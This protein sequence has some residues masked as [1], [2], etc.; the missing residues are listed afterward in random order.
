MTLARPAWLYLAYA[1]TLT[2]GMA[3]SGL[4]FNLLLAARGYGEATLWLPVVG[5]RSL[6]G[7]MNSL[8]VLAAG[9]SSLPLWWL[10]GRLGPRVA[11]LLGALLAAASLLGVALLRTPLPALA[12]AC[13]GGPAAVLFQVS[14]A[15]LMMRLSGPHA[16]DLLFSI[17]AGANIGVG[18]LGSLA[19]GLIAGALADRLGLAPQSEAAYSATFIVAAGIVLLALAP[20]LLLR[21]SDALQ[22]ALP[23][24]GPTTNDQPQAT[25]ASTAWPRA[26]VPADDTALTDSGKPW[27]RLL[28]AL[29]HWSMVLRQT[30][31]YLV[32]PLLISCGAALLIPYLSL[33]FRLRYGAPDAALGLIFALIG[34]STGAA[35]LLAPLLSARLGKMG[36]VVLTQALAIPCLLLLGWA[37]LL[38]LAV[39]IAVA[40]GA[41]MNMASPLYDAHAMEQTAEPLRPLVI[42]LINGAFAAGYVVGPT[43]SAEVQRAYGFAPLFVATATCYAL[44][45]LAN[46]WLFVRPR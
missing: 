28:A 45:A 17:N 31:R 7:L 41:L 46:Y 4:F 3:I 12:A 19:G 15:P 10:V 32:S 9:L 16:R 38:W 44:A 25:D 11:L 35:T 42:G 34:V 8:P 6:L 33:Y 21:E 14:A 20:L 40:R 18:G 5:E 36:S 30:A 43:I 22:P 13:L 37:P 1:A 24:Q 23:D 29:G 2:F 27:P 26:A 39:P